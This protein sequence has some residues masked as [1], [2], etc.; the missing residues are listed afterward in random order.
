MGFILAAVGLTFTLAPFVWLVLGDYQ[1]AAI[2]FTGVLIGPY[3][4][5]LGYVALWGGLFGTEPPF[6]KPFG[7]LVRRVAR[8]LARPI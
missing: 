7:A 5:F 6:A 2:T 4:A 1:L 8:R 3:F